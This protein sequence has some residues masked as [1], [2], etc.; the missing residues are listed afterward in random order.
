MLNCSWQQQDFSTT[1]QNISGSCYLVIPFC[2]HWDELDPS[3]LLLSLQS[4]FWLKAKVLHHIL[5]GHEFQPPTFSVPHCSTPIF[6]G[7][8]TGLKSCSATHQTEQN[9]HVPWPADY[10]TAQY[11]IGS[12]PGSLGL[13]LLLHP[14]SPDAVHHYPLKCHT[15]HLSLLSFM[16]F[17]SA[18]FFN[19]SGSLWEAVLL[20][21]MSTTLTWYFEQLAESTLKPIIHVVNK[22]I[23]QYWA[24]RSI[25][26]NSHYPLGPKVQGISQQLF[27]PFLLPMYLHS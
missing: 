17:L 23:K 7:I 24:L 22:E 9:N 20:S 27:S 3:F 8:K 1:S 5:R 6:W 4:L 14:R 21:K 15:S 16:R 2:I 18:H 19:P 26:W 12:L 13:F 11:T 25:S 10:I